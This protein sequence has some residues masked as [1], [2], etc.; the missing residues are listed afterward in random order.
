M[1]VQLYKTNP[2]A[3]VTHVQIG[4]AWWLFTVNGL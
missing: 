2:A 3:Q 1:L 4:Q